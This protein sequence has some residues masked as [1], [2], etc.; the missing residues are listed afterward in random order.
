ME[1]APGYTPQV[2]ELRPAALFAFFKVFP[3]FVCSAGFLF[4]AWRL[5]P[6]LIWL[7]L[8]CLAFGLYRYIYT[9]TI[10]YLITPEIIR[11]RRGICFKRTDQV[12]LFRVKDY[13]QTQSL[14]LQLFRLMDLCLKSTDPIN[15]IIW[16]RGIPASDLVDVL[17]D[18]VKETRGHN[19]IVELN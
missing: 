8:F 6:G 15:P 17:R 12:E 11:I 7:S 3:F 19:Q 10:Y 14:F 9:R 18:R 4:L 5:W 1:I 13:I 2:I 16:L